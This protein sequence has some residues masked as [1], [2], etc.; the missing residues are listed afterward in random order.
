MAGKHAD[1][2][3]S[4]VADYA[5]AHPYVTAHASSSGLTGTLIHSALAAMGAVGGQ[6][7]SDDQLAAGALDALRQAP[8]GLT[9]AG[10]AAFLATMAEESAHFRTTTEY[11]TGQSYAPYIGR[12]F[13]QL[14]WSS[15]YAG[16][17]AWCKARGLVSDANVFVHSPTALS[18]IRWAWLGGVYYFAAHDLWRYANAGN[19]LAVSQ[20][21][22]GGD[23]KI[24]TS[25]TPNGWTERQNAYRAFLAAG[26]SLLPTSPAAAPVTGA[27]QQLLLT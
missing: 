13:E 4:G 8:A 10:A 11:G 9:A 23:G 17:G 16:F 20:A 3:G 25:F 24:G 7:V 5:E 19:F 2:D 14:T 27:Q 18:D 6:I 15:N 12:T 22:N 1:G 21:V 26:A